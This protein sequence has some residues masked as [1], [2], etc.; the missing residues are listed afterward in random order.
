MALLKSDKNEIA[1][2]V[3]LAAGLVAPGGWCIPCFVLAA[4]AL[5]AC[6][7]YRKKGE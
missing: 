5:F 3:Y 1:F 7:Y 6:A 4:T 2:D